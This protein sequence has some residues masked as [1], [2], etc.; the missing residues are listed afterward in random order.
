MY[1]VLFISCNEFY[2]TIEQ[3]V[4]TINYETHIVHGL[5][6]YDRGV[7]FC[8]SMMENIEE[9][10]MRHKDF[11]R[12]YIL[13][14]GS[15]DILVLCVIIMPINNPHVLYENKLKSK[16]ITVWKDFT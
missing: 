6:E 14:R 9:D 12:S 2:F 8:C 3:E 5:L 10:A 16:G 4:I 11:R 15:L 1:I 7:E 13:S